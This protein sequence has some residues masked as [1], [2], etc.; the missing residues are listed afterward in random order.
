MSKRL[1]SVTGDNHLSPPFFVYTI[2]K[3]LITQNVWFPVSSRFLLSFAYGS[4]LF[5][6]CGISCHLALA[7]ISL[8][9]P[10]Y[11]LALTGSVFQLCSSSVFYWLF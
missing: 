5:T 9:I 11:L 3:T 4:L 8:L 1:F 6:K 10:S 7:P 2:Q